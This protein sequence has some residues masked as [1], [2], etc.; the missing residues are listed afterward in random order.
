MDPGIINL[1]CEFGSCIC[2][3]YLLPA[4]PALV[5]MMLYYISS[6]N[7]AATFCLDFENYAYRK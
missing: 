1:N 2:Q 4:P 6:G 3:I 5:V 7:A